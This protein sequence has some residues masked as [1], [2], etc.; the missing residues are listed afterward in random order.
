MKNVQRSW[1]ICY[2]SIVVTAHA[3]TRA[4]QS[5]APL[6]P[7]VMGHQN[8]DTPGPIQSCD[9]NARSWNVN[10]MNGTDTAKRERCREGG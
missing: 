8:A 9:N 3:D 4:R 7:N 1:T 2:R 6:V 10:G 5:T